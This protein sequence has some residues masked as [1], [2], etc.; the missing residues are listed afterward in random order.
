MSTEYF[1]YSIHVYACAD[2]SFDVNIVRSTYPSQGHWKNTYATILTGINVG[3]GR[4]LDEVDIALTT[5]MGLARR[6]QGHQSTAK[7]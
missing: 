1:T 5:A 7:P 3:P 4:V 6:D 2:G